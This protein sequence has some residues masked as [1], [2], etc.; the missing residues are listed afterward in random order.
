MSELLGKGCEIIVFFEERFLVRDIE[1]SIIKKYRKNL[2]FK[3][4]K[5]IRDYKLVE[6]GDKIVVVIFGGKDSIFM[7]KMF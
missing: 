3:F 6:E 7:V 1:K 2:W 5:V 4:M